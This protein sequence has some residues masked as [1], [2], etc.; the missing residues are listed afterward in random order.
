MSDGQQDTAALLNALS[1]NIKMLPEG[2]ALDAAVNA[3]VA[4]CD[5]LAANARYYTAG[6]TF[7]SEPTR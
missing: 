2:A 3:Y 7:V 6:L 1:Y 4:L 5:A